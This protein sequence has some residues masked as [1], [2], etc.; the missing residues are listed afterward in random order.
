MT[1]F[2][3]F[4]LWGKDIGT[5]KT[6]QFNECSKSGFRLMN[7]RTTCLEENPE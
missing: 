1:T 4:S 7:D 3:N 6:I 5:R 2:D